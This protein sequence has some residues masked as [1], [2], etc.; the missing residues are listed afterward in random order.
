MKGPESE[1]AIVTEEAALGGWNDPRLP[2]QGKPRTVDIVCWAAIVLSG[3]YYWLTL[4]VRVHLVGTHPVISEL[5]GGGTESIISAAAFVRTGHGTI[6]VVM[7]AAIPGIM[8]F[9][10]LWWWAGRLWGEPLIILLSGKRERGPRYMARVR[11]WG[12]KFTWPAVVLSP[13]LPFPNAIIFVIVGWAG[14]KL[15]TFLV[16]DLIG[17]L[18]WTGLLAGLGYAI[19]HP[20]VKVAQ[21]ISH[22]GLWVSIGLVVIIVFFQVRSQRRM[23]AEMRAK[24]AAAGPA[25]PGPSAPGPSAATAATPDPAVAADSGDA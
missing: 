19:G 17:T 15:R 22:Y 25:A 2:W 4:P 13:F 3:L 5:L 6:V 14:M 8:K 7:L 16:L 21:T 11:R 24:R 20:A 18:L 9:D 23:L 1:P 12:K 10:P